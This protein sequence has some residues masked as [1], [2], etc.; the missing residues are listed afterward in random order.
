LVVEAHAVLSDPH[1]RERYDLGEDE[2]GM[3]ESSH[4]R[5][6]GGVHPDLA[7]VFAQFSA[8]PGGGY[9]FGAGGPHGFRGF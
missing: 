9:P 3:T 1:R 2:D 5:G 4:M 8:G 7:S 6:G